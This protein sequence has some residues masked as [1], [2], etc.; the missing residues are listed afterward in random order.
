MY[1]AVGLANFPEEAITAFAGPTLATV[2]LSVQVPLAVLADGILGS[3]PWLHSIA[4]A[5]LMVCGAAGVLI[6]F[7]GVTLSTGQVQSST[8]VSHNSEEELTDQPTPEG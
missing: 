1:A 8:L 7:L 2:G 3:P 5:V 4:S 6:G